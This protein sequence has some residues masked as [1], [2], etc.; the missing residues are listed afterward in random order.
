MTK[1]QL[2]EWV[3]K[4]KTLK[5]VFNDVADGTQVYA[6]LLIENKI[7]IGE[8]IELYKDEKIKVGGTDD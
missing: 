8:L 3:K 7:T 4:N 5:E 2:L 1:E 6:K